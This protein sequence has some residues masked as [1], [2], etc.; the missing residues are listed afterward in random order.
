MDNANKNLLDAMYANINPFSN[1]SKDS[2]DPCQP[3]CETR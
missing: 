1:S 3:A 2:D